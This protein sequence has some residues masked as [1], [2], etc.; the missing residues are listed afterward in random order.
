MHFVSPSCTNDSR[1]N[2][3]AGFT[4][5]ELMMVLVV[6][7]ILLTVAGPGF[8]SLIRD[9]RMTVTS[10]A[11]A[12]TLNAARAKAI[13]QRKI[14]TVCSSAN[15]SS[16]GGN[17]GNG[18]ISFLD[19]NGNASVDAG[20]EILH[21]HANLPLAVSVS[22]TGTTE[23]RF[24]NQGF[25]SSGSSG[26]FLICDARGDSHARALLVSNTG[27]ISTATDSDSD[28]IVNDASGNNIV[29]P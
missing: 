14:V 27:R 23:I 9:N 24:T 22:L 5:I 17:W 12:G 26:T 11:I 8:S 28:G 10:N 20:D 6:A 3:S 13:A 4:L 18:W 7:V 21:Y 16:C 19:N 25:V 29:C 2:P 1:V 15:G